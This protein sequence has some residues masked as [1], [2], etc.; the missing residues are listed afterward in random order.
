MQKDPNKIKFRLPF[1]DGEASGWG[2]LALVVV[3][4]IVCMT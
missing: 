1:M 3:V 4:L 2:I